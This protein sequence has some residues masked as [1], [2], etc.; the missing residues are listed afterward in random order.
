MSRQSSRGKAW[1]LGPPPDLLILGLPCHFGESE[2]L[3]LGSFKI[4]QGVTQG[5]PYPPPSSM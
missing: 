4:V 1:V 3:S 5:D 2:K